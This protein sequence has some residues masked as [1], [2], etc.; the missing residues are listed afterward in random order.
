[1]LTLH[2]ELLH[3]HLRAASA[4]DLALTRDGDPGEWPPSPARLVAALTAADGTR[5]RCRV[6][7]GKELSLF[8]TA[9]PPRMYASPPGDVLRSPQRARFVVIND[10]RA[11]TVQEYPAREA[12][13][14]RP[15]TRLCPADP[16]IAYVWDSLQPT[17]EQLVA[18]ARRAARVGYIGCA[19]SPARVTVATRLEP[20]SAPATIWEVDADGQHALPVPF[21]GF[22]DVL[23]RAFD[24]WAAGQPV[25]RGW[26]RTELARYRAPDDAP[27]VA[28]EA[29]WPTTIWLRFDRSLP[30]R[31]ALRVAERL[32]SA[33]IDLYQR[34]VA[35]EAGE[36]PWV[37]HGHNR[38]AA[39]GYRVAQWVA[40]P[41]VGH[42]HARGQLHGAAIML[43]RL[44]PRVEEGVR[45][46]IW[47]LHNLVVP[48][49][50]TVGVQPH[51]GERQPIAAHPSRWRGPARRWL[52]A[53]PVVHERRV[54]GG[55]GLA[56][57]ALWCRHAGTE[58]PRRARLS[59]VPLLEGTPGFT[60]QEIFRDREGARR[61]YSYLE[62]EFDRP[63]EG[64]IVLGRGRQFGMG[65]MLPDP[66]RRGDDA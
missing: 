40:L 53:T 59:P 30:G 20:S 21:P 11:S 43:P 39:Q 41:A 51:G 2:V 65:L 58:A 31:A 56:D 15:G 52:S 32:K 17:D 13:A 16:R 57:V 23:D 47:H 35:G 7:S 66:T 54:R 22:V 61:P 6:T 5:D 37:L 49:L 36:V 50:P 19:D 18:L 60:S 26:F 3:G 48:G 33:V 46:A 29:A 14:V 4:D 55:P 25:R 64:P 45:H 1:M 28:D 34:H 44:D 12:Q 42:P 8:E 63:V 10:R 24:A 62:M 27:A 9:P 38:E